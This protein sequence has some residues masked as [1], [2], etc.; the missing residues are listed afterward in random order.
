MIN[1][2]GAR[3]QEAVIAR[4]HWGTSGEGYI[5]TWST[6][7]PYI[8]WQ[9]REVPNWQRAITD[10]RLRKALL[11]AIDRDG[12]NET[13]NL[14]F[15]PV[16]HAFIS[17]QDALFPEVDRVITKYPYDPN[18]ATALLSE[19]GWRRQTN[20]GPLFDA[21]GQSLDVELMTTANQESQSTII[22]DNWKAAG[23]N[24]TMFVV[25]QARA[26]D[27]ELASS[28]PAARVNNRQLGTENFIWTANEF[29][30]PENRWTGSNRG[31][32]SDEEIERLQRIRMTSL[33]ENERRQST[34]ALLKRMTDLA[35]P[36]PFLYSAEF[37]IARKYV[38][39]PLGR[40]PSQNGLTWNVHE[41]ELNR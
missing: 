26:R 9:F 3:A 28:F 33:D 7:A 18:R 4:D 30:L 38:R 2:P 22:V 12:L 10:V 6:G 41:W 16:A 29:S 27:G 15:T 31:N 36:A 11:H 17:P 25:P 37:V 13:I 1:T 32:F 8:D 34:I 35:G 5:N 39:G 24:S 20:D 19:A 40:M 14:G 23:A 21:T